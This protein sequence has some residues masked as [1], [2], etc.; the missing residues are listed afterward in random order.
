MGDFKDIPVILLG[1]QHVHGNDLL[2]SIEKKIEMLIKSHKETL[3]NA[4]KVIGFPVKREDGIIHSNS[5]HAHTHIH[6]HT[7]VL[8]LSGLYILVLPNI[9]LFRPRMVF[10]F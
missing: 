9:F 4:V 1:S 2:N 7:C 8:Q 6:I 10:N 3:N 5:I